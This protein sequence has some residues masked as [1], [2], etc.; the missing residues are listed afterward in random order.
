MASISAATQ[1]MVRSLSWKEVQGAAE[2]LKDRL[3]G[4]VA[5]WGV[6]IGGSVV[7]ALLWASFEILDG[8]EDGCVVIDD[9]MD[10][11]RTLEPWMKKGYRVDALYRK[12]WSPA[13]VAPEAENVG[14]VWLRF[15]WEHEEDSSAEDLVRRLLQRLNQDTA[16]EALR[17]TPRRVASVLR[18]FTTEGECEA[19]DILKTTFASPG[20]E[21][22]VIRDIPFHSLCEHHM[23]PF[24]GTVSIGYIPKGR[25]VGLSKLPRLV[26]ALSR[27]LQIQERLATDIGQAIEEA[28]EPLG[29]GV[30]IKGIHSC[31]AMR[32]ARSTGEM[33]TQFISGVFRD[34]DAARAEFLAAIR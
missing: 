30:V 19:S 34:K 28:L 7:A 17:D 25:I 26:H 3:P 29:T 15:P 13:R 8:P 1:G 16:S 14:R 9:L 21:L 5:V 33:V 4:V 32:G 2:R 12:E 6:P 10:S 22:I 20:D 31:M 27:R 23:L 18:E 24:S 11:G